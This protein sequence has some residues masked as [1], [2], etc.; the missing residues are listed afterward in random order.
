MN[1]LPSLDD[2]KVPASASGRSIK[3]FKTAFRASTYVLVLLIATG[4]TFISTRQPDRPDSK[5]E[6]VKKA[7]PTPPPVPAAPPAVVVTKSEVAQTAEKP[8][9]PPVK[10]VQDERVSTS[11]G[12]EGG[13]VVLFPRMVPGSDSAIIR[14]TAQLVQGRLMGQL[15]AAYP[16]KPVDVRPAPQRVCPL[17]GCKGLAVG[18]MI[19]HR[20]GGCAVVATVGPPGTIPRTLIPWVGDVKLKSSEFPFREPPENYVTIKDMVPCDKVIDR[21][22]ERQDEV[23]QTIKANIK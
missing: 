5:V 1:T 3:R 18:A 12:Q 4:C 10:I 19:A 20:S 8:P 15:R 14:P 7:E 22:A 6:H 21:L 9:P 2:A 11:R 16:G 13:I 17:A 23:I